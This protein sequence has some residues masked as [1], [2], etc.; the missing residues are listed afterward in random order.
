MN[1]CAKFHWNP[2]T[3]YRDIASR[4]ID[5]NRR[6][7][8]RTDGRREGRNTSP[9]SNR[10]SLVAPQSWHPAKKSSINTNRKSAMRF[11]MS[12]RWSSYFAPK[13]PSKKRFS[14]KIALRL[15]KVCYKV[16]LCEQ[17]QRQSC[18]AFVGLTIRTKMIGGDL[19]LI[20]IW[21]CRRIERCRSRWSPYH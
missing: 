8:G 13:P 1:I 10:Y 19:S 15:E 4:A 16:S 6:T 12:L 3:E 5:V 2:S 14:C 21:R 7:D 17:C 18:K 11:P 9:I 20:H